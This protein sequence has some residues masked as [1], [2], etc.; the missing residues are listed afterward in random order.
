MLFDNVNK[1]NVALPARNSENKL[2]NVGHLVTH[3]VE[4]LIKDPRKE[5][6]VQNGSM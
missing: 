3:I 4:K 1:H 6:F 2:T 5:L